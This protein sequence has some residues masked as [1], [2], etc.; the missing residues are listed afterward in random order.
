MER[1]DRDRW[2]SVSLAVCGPNGPKP[3]KKK[4]KI[5]IVIITTTKRYFS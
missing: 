1:I 4:K 2:Q 3:R 5:K